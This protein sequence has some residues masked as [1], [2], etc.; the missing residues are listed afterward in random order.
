MDVGMMNI[1]K[2]DTTTSVNNKRVI[3]DFLK[4]FP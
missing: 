2:Y 4:T 3:D 1:M